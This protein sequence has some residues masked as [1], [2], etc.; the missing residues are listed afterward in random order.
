[1]ITIQR[2]VQ[3]NVNTLQQLH[4][5][6]VSTLLRIYDIIVNAYP[7]TPYYDILEK[8]TELETGQ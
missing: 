8:T 6:F 7:F 3:L 4:A 5:Y 2:V 1:M